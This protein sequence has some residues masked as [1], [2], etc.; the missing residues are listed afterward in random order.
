[1]RLLERTLY[2]QQFE[3][4]DS[5]E[6]DEYK[7]WS[8]ILTFPWP[9]QY[10]AS[11]SLYYVQ[12]HPCRGTL[13]QKHQLHR[14]SHKLQTNRKATY[15]SN[16]QK[17]ASTLKDREFFS[18]NWKVKFLFHHL[19]VPAKTYIYDRQSLQSGL[20]QDNFRKIK[21][22][23]RYSQ[24]LKVQLAS[25]MFLAYRNSGRVRGRMFS[26]CVFLNLNEA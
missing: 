21:S 5:E 7:S 8:Y 16:K 22:Q 9:L 10:K 13:C 11:A 15:Q 26:A 20:I 1:M 12:L 18:E 4:E 3:N 23:L 17:C 25:I 6:N 24:S 2:L 14:V 19:K